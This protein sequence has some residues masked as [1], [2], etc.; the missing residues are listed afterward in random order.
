MTQQKRQLEDWITSYLDYAD[1]TE[2]TFNFKQWSAI[3]GIAACLQRKCRLEWGSETFF[4]NM[5]VVLVAPPGGARK[6]TAMKPIQQFLGELEIKLAPDSVT[7]EALIQA[8]EESCQTIEDEHG[9]DI[10]LHCSLTAFCPEL[11]VFIGNQNYNFISEL[12]DWFDCKDRWEWKTKKSGVNVIDNLFFNLIGA[13]TP[14]LIKT[15]LP[16]EIIGGGLASRMLFVFEAK[17]EKICPFPTFK[18]EL[19]T[20]LIEDLRQIQELKGVFKY[21]RE[22]IDRY[23]DWYTDHDKNPPFT[24]DRFTGYNSR[25]QVHLLKLCMIMSASRS[26]EMVIELRDFERALGALKKIEYKM[27][28][29]FG[30]FGRLSE[31]DIMNSI[32][33]TIGTHGEVMFSDI[34]SKYLQD[35]DAKTLEQMVSALEKANYIN[36][37]EMPGIGVKLVYRGESSN[38]LAQSLGTNKET[39]A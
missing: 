5:Y 26:N 32:M 33:T 4:P 29:A 11:A 39:G 12:T 14:D 10:G 19:R 18:K 23:I 36:I 22:V 8:L 17:K 37:V 16:I 2:S 9:K 35:V 15:T 34:M 6:G 20:P 21:T 25:R 24:S 7:R 30:S 1:N 27:P 31:A 28:Q 13:T 38:T 3:S